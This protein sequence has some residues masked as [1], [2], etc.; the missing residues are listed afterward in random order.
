MNQKIKEIWQE[1]R[2]AM[3]IFVIRQGLDHLECVFRSFLYEDKKQ[4]VTVA[5]EA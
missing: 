4:H 5:G 1:R 3:R 2:K